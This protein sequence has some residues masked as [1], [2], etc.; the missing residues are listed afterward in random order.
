MKCPQGKHYISLVNGLECA[1]FRE[2]Y[3]ER[4]YRTDCRDVQG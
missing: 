1:I 2:V 4:T 3:D